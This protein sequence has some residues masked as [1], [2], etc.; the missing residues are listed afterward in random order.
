MSDKLVKA[1]LEASMELGSLKSL[2][3]ANEVPMLLIDTSGSMSSLMNMERRRIDGLREAVN[4][5]QNETPV[6]MLSFGATTGLGEPDVR[7]VEHVPEPCGGTPL[8]RAI[9]M[10]R[11]NG[12]TRVVVISDGEPDLPTESLDAARR[13]GGR[14]DIIYVGE[15]GGPGSAF[16][17]QLARATGGDKFDG[18]LT[19]TRQLVGKVIGLLTGNVAPQDAPRVFTADATGNIT[20][21]AEDLEDDED[22][23]DAEDGDDD[24]D[25]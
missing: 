2:V 6:P 23:E 25:Q 15:E 24:E 8:H 19:E 1:K 18:K 5:I 11:D 10:A 12:A 14:I 4:M 22:D 20:D 21:D 17:K 7:F 13:F 3:D 9:D 16:L